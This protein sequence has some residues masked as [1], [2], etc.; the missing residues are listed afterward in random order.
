MTSAMKP[1][2]VAVSDGEWNRIMEELSEKAPEEV[3]VKPGRTLLARSPLLAC[4]AA[5]LYSTVL[6]A[7]HV[8]EMVCFAV[9]CIFYLLRKQ[10]SR[11]GGA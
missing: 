1:Y 7:V 3:F 4:Q 11:K 5:C 6:L 2:F 8:S 9:L 10:C